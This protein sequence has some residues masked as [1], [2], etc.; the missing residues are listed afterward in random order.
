MNSQYLSLTFSQESFIMVST[1]TPY[2]NAH[3]SQFFPQFIHLHLSRYFSS[4]H[5]RCTSIGSSQDKDRQAIFSNPHRAILPPSH[6]RLPVSIPPFG[7]CLDQS[8]SGMWDL[9]GEGRKFRREG[10]WAC[11]VCRSKE[12]KGASIGRT[13]YCRSPAGPIYWRLVSVNDMEELA[14]NEFGE[15]KVHVTDRFCSS[16]KR[17]LDEVATVPSKR[18]RNKIAGCEYMQLLKIC[19]QTLTEGQSPPT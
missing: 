15:N 13:G 3:S 2:P 16:N 8:E 17:I 19:L 7:H 1:H 12:K 9:R 5:N 6:P 11:A 14:N 10:I 18:L 4:T